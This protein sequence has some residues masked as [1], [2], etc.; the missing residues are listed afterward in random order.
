[1]KYD[2][3]IYAA[4]ED[5]PESECQNLVEILW[6]IGQAK[7]VRSEA[8]QEKL[9]N[10]AELLF[11]LQSLIAAGKIAE[12]SRGRY[13]DAV[14]RSCPRTFSGV[15]E[16]EYEEACTAYYQRLREHGQRLRDM[17]MWI[18]D[19]A[20]WPGPDRAR[21]GISERGDIVS[22]SP[23][24]QFA[25]I[26]YSCAEVN[27]AWE[28]GLLALLKGPP[29][30]PTVI[31]RPANFTCYVGPGHL[32]QWLAGGR[33]CVVAPYLFNQAA[34]NVELLALTFLDVPERTFA[35][36]ETPDILHFVGARIFEEQDHWVIRSRPD[37][38]GERKETKLLPG[39]LTWDSWTNLR[40]T[41]PGPSPASLRGPA[42]LQP[43]TRR[44]SGA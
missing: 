35:H 5:R 11:N 26:L 10:H 29:Q 8:D 13:Y 17:S 32:V 44:K 41:S 7:G 24:G 18:R 42:P 14:A 15:S 40:G 23:D 30:N 31:L 33:Y 38:H 2:H 27:I 6:H 43:L 21:W 28:V 34:N 25:C 39:R 20:D 19:V 22:P 12:A 9:P 36:Y 16:S 1:M 3:Y 4:V 37:P